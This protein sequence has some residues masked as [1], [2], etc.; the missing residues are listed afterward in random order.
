MNFRDFSG[1]LVVKTSYFQC[2]NISSIPDGG[3]KI[4]YVAWQNQKKIFF[5]IN[6]KKNCDAIDSN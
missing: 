3:T 2:R 1:G 5:S 4:P 6:L